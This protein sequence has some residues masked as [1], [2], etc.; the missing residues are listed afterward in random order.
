[1]SQKIYLISFH[2]SVQHGEELHGRLR[3]SPDFQQGAPRVE[4]VLLR[5]HP[6]RGLHRLVRSNRRELEDSTA[7]GLERD[8]SRTEHPGC[9][10]YQT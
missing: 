8:G 5:S 6:A 9:Q 7:S 10:G 4:P 3:Q 2:Y 1:M